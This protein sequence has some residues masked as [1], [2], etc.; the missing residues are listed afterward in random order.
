MNHQ[1][2]DP[3]ASS[4]WGWSEVVSLVRTA[5]DARMIVRLFRYMRDQIGEPVSWWRTEELPDLTEAD[6]RRVTARDF[7]VNDRYYVLMRGLK[8]IALDPAECVQR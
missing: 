3:L 2:I 5:H 8:P 6:W 1:P 7:S 4:P